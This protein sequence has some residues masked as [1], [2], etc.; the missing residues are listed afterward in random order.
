MLKVGVVG[1]GRIG[2]RHALG[3]QSHPDCKLVCVCDLVKAKADERAAELGVKAYYSVPEMLASEPLDAVGVI[4]AD[5]LHFE[6]TMQALEAGKHV[7]VEKPLAHEVGLARQLVAKA[8]ERGVFLSIDYNRRF[9]EG[10]HWAKTWQE[11]GLLG[12]PAYIN[13]RIAQRGPYA[14]SW[15][16]PYHLLYDLHVHMFDVLRHFAGEVEALSTEMCDPRDTGYYTSIATSVKFTSGAVGNLLVSWDSSF[17]H[18]IEYMELCGD[19]ARIEVHN[20]TEQ[21]VLLPHD[22]DVRMVRKAG[23]MQAEA[24]VFDNTFARR[25]HAF[26]SDLTAG[27]TPYPLGVDGLRALELIQAAIRSFEEGR[28]VRVAEVTA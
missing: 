14:S 25:V 15:L 12:K 5:A 2:R 8:N 1:C 20:I 19:K 26:V 3:Y 23:A 13:L 17:R 6:P 28:R 11:E 27:R 21:A 10:Y 24:A 22:A 16:K 9:A 4:T 18:E 7:L